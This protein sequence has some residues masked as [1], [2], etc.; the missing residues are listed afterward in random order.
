MSE[1]EAAAAPG[2]DENYCNP[3]LSR[4]MHVME[5]ISAGQLVKWV[6]RCSLCGWIDKADL[7]G[8]AEDAI[9][10][11]MSQRAQRIALASQ[12]E[13]FSFVQSSTDQLSIE[14]VLF[15][16]LG[17]ASVCWERQTLLEVG[18]FDSTRAKAV[19]EALLKE[20]QRFMRLEREDVL[21]A[22]RD[23]LRSGS[24]TPMKDIEEQL[25]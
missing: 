19:G 5:A 7:D 22:V 23:V 4:D 2:P 18:V 11:A 17:A 6:N 15:Q 8:W 16:A 12:T 14:E 13:P 21:D 24:A 10:K 1:A 3:S 9:K 25:K 20:V